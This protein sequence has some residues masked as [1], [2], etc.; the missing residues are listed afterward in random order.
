M[1]DMSGMAEL[2]QLAAVQHG[3]AARRQA[4]QL[5]L[6]A[7]ALRHAL[8]SGDWERATSRVIGLVGRPS[9]G[10]EAGMT[11]ALHHGP[12]AFVSGPSALALWQ[13]PGFDLE[14]VQI[15]SRRPISRRSTTIGLVHT[16]TDL[17]DSHIGVVRGIPV[18]TPVRAIFDIA[19]VL[20]PKRVERALDNAWTR[21]LLN[22]SLLGRVV[23]EL[24][25]RGRPGTVLMRELT[26][27]RPI[28]F[29]PP[30]SS[31]EA[32]VNE[33]L[34]QAGEKALRRQVNAGNEDSWLGRF[35]LADRDL[36]L[37]L[38]VHSELFHGSKLDQQRDAARRAA[39]SAAGWHFIE[40]WENEVWR[41][42]DVVVARVVN[43][44]RLLR[45]AA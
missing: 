36:P 11:A 4:Y 19:G 14:P 13:V 34:A 3:V 32:R 7:S 20:H 27:A 28:D 45:R 23:S 5:G 39:M 31:T 17:L 29:R 1:S 12:E 10:F 44:R 9:T 43:A 33:I 16:T 42:P 38:E 18:V 8:K 2:R 25:E 15:L 21:R 24:G 41:H 22:G 40:A 30:E 35:D 6:T 37:V 26:E